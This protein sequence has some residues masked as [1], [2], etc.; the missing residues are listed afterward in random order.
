L[1]V[2]ADFFGPGVKDDKIVDDLEQTLFVA[3]LGQVAVE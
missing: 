1:A 3:E 2:A